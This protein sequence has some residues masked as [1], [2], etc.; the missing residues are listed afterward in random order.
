MYGNEERNFFISSFTESDTQHDTELTNTSTKWSQILQANDPPWGRVG[1]LISLYGEHRITLHHSSSYKKV[2]IHLSWRQRNQ[3]NKKGHDS[4]WIFLLHISVYFLYF[5]HFNLKV[6]TREKAF[7]PLARVIL[8][9]ES[10][11]SI[12]HISNHVFF[13]PETS[14]M[15]DLCAEMICIITAYG[16]TPAFP[17]K[18]SVFKFLD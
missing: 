11:I 15:V 4:R 5:I 1:V 8:P 6:G 13:P 3:T 12:S 7:D 18:S 14:L 16:H 17:I 9:I 2:P 10:S